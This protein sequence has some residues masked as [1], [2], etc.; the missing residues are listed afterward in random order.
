MFYV[1]AFLIGTII[2]WVILLIVVPIAQKLANFGMPPWPETL[3]K[4][5]VIS[6]G[7]NLVSLVLDPVHWLVGVI[8]SG[9]VFFTLM[10]KW[11]QVDLFGGII[12]VLVGW[13]VRN[14]LMMFVLGSLASLS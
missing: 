2:T 5:A 11:F 10:V 8:V 9:I 6:G 12:I 1:L 14:V 7:V 3:W 13:I 4:L